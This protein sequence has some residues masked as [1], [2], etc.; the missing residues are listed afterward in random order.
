MHTC[1]HT[2]C[3]LALNTLLGHPPRHAPFTVIESRVRLS[4][5]EHRCNHF[6]RRMRIDGTT[7]VGMC[8]CV[9]VCLYA[10]VCVLMCVCACV[11]VLMCVRVCTFTPYSVPVR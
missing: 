4:I 6:V 9:C 7:R 5:A 1:M 8:V 11:C 2:V 3:A 10:C